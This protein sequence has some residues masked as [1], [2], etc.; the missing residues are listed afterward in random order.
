AN[1]YI[2]IDVAGKLWVAGGGDPAYVEEYSPTANGNATPLRKI[3]GPATGLSGAVDVAVYGARPSAPRSVKAHA[4]KHKVSLRWHAPA[5]N[6]G[7]LAAYLVER[8]NS[9]HAHWAAIAVTKKRRIADRHRK[10]HHRYR[11]R[12]IAV[13]QMGFSPASK[14]AS[15]VTPGAKHH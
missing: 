4:G 2:S 5:D 15:A 8:K 3:S 9:K 10:A 13:N 12:V 14:T 11:Y 6:G 1:F 7:G